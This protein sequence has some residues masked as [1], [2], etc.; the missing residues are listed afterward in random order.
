MEE[1]VLGIC[2]LLGMCLKHCWATHTEGRLHVEYVVAIRV[3]PWPVQHDI[4]EVRQLFVAAHYALDGVLQHMEADV[5][6]HA[7]WQPA[8]IAV[9]LSAPSGCSPGCR[10]GPGGCCAGLPEHISVLSAPFVV[11]MLLAR[12]HL[13]S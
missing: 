4:V 2:R 3:V 12:G 11:A 13:Q 6:T 10:W 9:L 5:H 1:Q 8:G 7:A